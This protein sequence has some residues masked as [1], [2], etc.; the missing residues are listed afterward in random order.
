MTALV[1]GAAGLIGSAVAR[2]AMAQGRSVRALSRPGGSAV[3]LPGADVHV[4]DVRVNDDALAEAL[5][6][7]HEV[8]H[9]AAY[10]AYAGDSA[11]DV[12][13]TAVDGTT[14]LMRAAANAGVKRLVVTS[15][16]IVFGYSRTPVALEE[17]GLSQSLDDEP[18][19][20]RAKA[21]Q[22]AA[23][24]ALAAE[25]GLDL[26]L[27]CPTMTIGGP[28]PTLGPSNGA[29]LAY[30]ADP[31]RCTFSGGANF[32]HVDDVA[33]GHLMLLDHGV[34]GQS[35]LLG[36]ENVRWPDLHAMLA[37]LAGVAPP[38]WE[39]NHTLGFLGGLAAEA[40]AKAQGRTPLTSRAQAGMMGR[41]YWYNSGK[42]MALGYA[43]RPL[44]AALS[45]ALAWLAASRHVSR[46]LRSTLHLHGD[47]YA[48][49][50]TA[51]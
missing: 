12:Q 7:V 2:L 4:A 15:S 25:L 11:R 47:V 51:A 1:T 49:R 13:G 16:S 6:D 3:A 46:S 40:V 22:D 35:Y 8:I 10:F 37:E 31:M 44:R 23:A 28:C 38:A 21:A 14:T 19:Y 33:A 34:A 42:A 50:A 9:C 39:I 24:R 43:P 20:V 17:C 30:L 41:Y 29:L 32:V 5:K 27:A 26:V 36:G 18:G 45:H 48:A